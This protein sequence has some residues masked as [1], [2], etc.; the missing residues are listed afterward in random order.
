MYLIWQY[1]HL[2]IP[3][4][5]DVSAEQPPDHNAIAERTLTAY[6]H[7]IASMFICLRMVEWCRAR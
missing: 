3:I 4:Y 2:A 1:S 7:F 6:N 5:R